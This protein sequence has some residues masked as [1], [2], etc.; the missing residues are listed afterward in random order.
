MINCLRITLI[1][2]VGLALSSCNIN[3]YIMLKESSDTEYDT[4]P[5]ND[6]KEY[7]IASNDVITL[8]FY[9]NG[10]FEILGVSAPGD[11]NSNAANQSMMQQQQGLL[12][13]NVE[14]DGKVKLPYLGKVELGGKTIREAEAQLVDLYDDIFVSPYILVNV[15]NRRVIV[16]RGNGASQVVPLVYNNT[17]VLEA[18]SLAGGID[19]RGKSKNIKVIRRLPSG[20][21]EIYKMDLS[22]LDG[23]AMAEMPVQAN[24]IIYIEPRKNFAGEVVKEIAPYLSI[25]SSALLIFTVSRTIK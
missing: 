23:L 7:R 8:R 22:H 19:T 20:G 25:I 10:G 9:K 6:Q 17:T 24:D 14:V 15:T 5:L 1:L 12:T 16:S 4:P 13:Y 2:T 21:H 18:I 3:S 11:A